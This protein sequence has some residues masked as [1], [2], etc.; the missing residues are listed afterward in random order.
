MQEVAQHVE[1]AYRNLDLE[2][3]GS[4]LHPEVRWTGV[5]DNRAEVLDWC[6]GLLADGIKAAV[7]SVEVDRDAVVLGLSVARQAEGAR[8]APPELLYQVLTVA[9]AQVI[10]IHVYP[11]RASALTRPVA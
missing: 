10:D 9:D 7:E 11:D 6:R 1:A 8:P 3:L 4:L 2:L 5:C